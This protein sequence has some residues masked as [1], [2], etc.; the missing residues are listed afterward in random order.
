M[1]VAHA[2]VVSVVKAMIRGDTVKKVTAKFFSSRVEIK[3]IKLPREDVIMRMVV[4]ITHKKV[5]K[6]SRRA[7]EKWVYEPEVVKETKP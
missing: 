4:K 3:K 5:V 1:A 7:I 6:K 2:K